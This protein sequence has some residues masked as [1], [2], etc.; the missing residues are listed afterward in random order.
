MQLGVGALAWATSLLLRGHFTRALPA[1]LGGGWLVW[2]VRPHLLALVAVAGAVPYFIGQV[3]TRSMPSFVT[4]PIGMA[5]I[6]LLVAFA[7]VSGA[8][9]LGIQSFSL[10]A[11][12]VQ[13]NDRTARSSEGGSAFSTGS[14]TLNPLKIPFGLVTVLFRP[15]LWEA[16]SAF[17]LLAAL[18]S[19]A[20]TVLIVKRF[21]S[22]RYAFRRWRREPFLL[23]C[24]VLLL[25]AGL[26]FS[27]FANFGLI[28]RQRS[29]VLPALYA[30]I[31]VQPPR[32][33]REWDLGDAG[34]PVRAGR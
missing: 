6:G 26:A 4:R 2:I 25:L 17:Q 10:N 23:Y 1:L 12:E 15:F 3:R 29:L 8:R 30:L 32:R 9:Y 22:L 11:V 20:V 5:V 7:V 28:S 33:G 16:R 34:R 31:A 21:D 18:E 27:A 19:A 13:L 14:D 24:I